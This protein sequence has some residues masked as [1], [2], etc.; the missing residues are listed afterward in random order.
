MKPILLIGGGGHC[1][2]VIDVIELEGKYKIV[3]IIDKLEN[4]GISILGYKVIGSDEDL[5]YLIKKY[6]YALITI[7]QINSA[8]L[9]I[10]MYNN[11]KKLGFLLPIIISPNAYVSSH[12][13][14]EEG[15]VIMHNVL[16]NSNVKIGIN[17][18]INSKA[19]IEHDCIIGDNC[20]LSTGSIINGNVIIGNGSFIGSNVVTKHEVQILE[21]SFIKAGSV[22]K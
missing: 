3:G 4:V 14:V 15:T 22:V 16:V 6:K 7:G 2:S 19:L 10:K 17:C 18:I 5:P 9:R 21:N 13:S 11:L 1:K 20:H 8:Q 12:S